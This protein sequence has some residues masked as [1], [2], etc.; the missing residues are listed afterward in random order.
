MLLALRRSD[1]PSLRFRVL[2]RDLLPVGAALHGESAAISK[3]RAT[4]LLTVGLKAAEIWSSQAPGRNLENVMVSGRPPTC[5]RMAVAE[6]RSPPQSIYLRY[7]VKE[8]YL[9][10]NDDAGSYEHAPPPARQIPYC[11]VRKLTITFVT[12]LVYS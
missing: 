11:R 10:L 5:P 6:A 8:I 1:E 12:D 9:I 2:T 7:L 3:A 4:E